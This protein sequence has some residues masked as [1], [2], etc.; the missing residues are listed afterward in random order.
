MGDISKNIS[1]HEIECPC[2][3][4]FDE[5]SQGC[6]D[7]WQGACDHFSE[8]LNRRVVLKINSGCRCQK[9]NDSLDGSAKHSQHILGNAIDGKIIGVPYFRLFNYFDSKYPNSHGIKLYTTFV[10]G[11]CRA[12]KWRA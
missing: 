7:M 2:G 6:V 9:H 3:C 1:N 10:H 4:G 12:E 11:D 8:M 5:I